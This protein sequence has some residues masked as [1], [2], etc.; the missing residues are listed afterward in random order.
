MNKLKLLAAMLVAGGAALSL[1]SCSDGGV[2]ESYAKEILKEA[3]DG[4]DVYYTYEEVS[5]KLEGSIIVDI[6]STTKTGTL[7]AVKGY[8][9]EEL[10][11]KMAADESFTVKGIFVSFLNGNATAAVYKDV[12]YSNIKIS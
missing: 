10:N 5:K 9:L 7:I 4:D 12:P 1:A 3:T 8:T 11:E 6:S 2:S